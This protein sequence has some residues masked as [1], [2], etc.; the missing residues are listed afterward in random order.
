[1]EKI[2]IIIVVKD[3]RL[4]F[5]KTIDSVKEIADEIIIIDIGLGE[6]TKNLIKNDKMVRLIKIKDEV[7]YVEMIR[8]KV[9]NLLN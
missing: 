2:S 6:K 4:H 5:L 8:E 3:N 9:K 7:K 1:M